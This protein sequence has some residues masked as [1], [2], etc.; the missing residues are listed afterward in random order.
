MDWL[1]Q[2]ADLIDRVLPDAIEIIIF[3]LLF[4]FVE[5]IK[6]AEKD[7]GFFK[8][9]MKNEIFL[10]TVNLLIFIPLSAFIV[11]IFIDVTLR[12]FVDEQLFADQIMALPLLLQIILGA[13]IIDFATY[14]RHKFTHYY[15]WSYHSVHH[16]VKHITWITGLRLHPIDIFVATLFTYVLLYF[17]GFSGA[18][19]LGAVILMKFM[20]YFTH[21]NLNLKFSKPLRYII[22]S[23]VYHRWHHATVERAYNT[24]F[25]GAFPFL[26]LL[27]GTYYHPEDLPEATGLSPAEQKNFPEFGYI[28]WL[29]YPFKRDYKF[30]KR[31]LSKNE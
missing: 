9:D 23:P 29:T 13:V 14:W 31:K 10:A 20:N 6:P 2:I 16:S 18:G 28:G 30:W 24:N 27:F 5:R 12:P 11:T 22:A 8:N 21:I 7:I 17:V 15:L 25:C 3:G 1:M 4:F 19:F 26:D